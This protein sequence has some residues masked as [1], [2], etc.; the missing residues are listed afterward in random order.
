MHF[1]HDLG[2]DDGLNGSYGL[3]LGLGN[4]MS[5]ASMAGLDSVHS[6][7]S[8]GFEDPNVSNH[9]QHPSQAQFRL[10]P[11]TTHPEH[12]LPPPTMLPSQHPN[13]N[14]ALAHGLTPLQQNM[15]GTS[16][17][18]SADSVARPRLSLIPT[19]PATWAAPPAAQ[20]MNGNTRAR[21]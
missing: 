8:L 18:M 11:F 15:L 14:T 2:K 21:R 7:G 13:H 19:T 1:T 12:I 17:R 9:I 3:S 5:Y 6:Q 16:T 20:Q 10:Q 4:G